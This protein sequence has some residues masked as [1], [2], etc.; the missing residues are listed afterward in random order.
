MGLEW[1]RHA[2]LEAGVD[3]A[4]VL[5]ERRDHC[6]LAFLDNEES[7]AEPDQCHDARDQAG[8]DAGTLHVGLEVGAVV[9]TGPAARAARASAL[10]TEQTAELAIEVAPEL[11]EIRRPVAASATAQHRPGC[12]GRRTRGTS[13]GTPSGTG[14]EAGQ[15]RARRRNRREQRRGASG[16]RGRLAHGHAKEMWVPEDRDSD[17]VSVTGIS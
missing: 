1:I 12:I 6:L 8:T 13:R 2:P 15:Q 9:V 14:H 4:A 5:A 3:R 10:A 16:I 11:V 17:G 7:A